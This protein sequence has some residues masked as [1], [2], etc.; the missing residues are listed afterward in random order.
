MPDQPDYRKISVSLIATVFNERNNIMELLESYRHQSVLAQEFIIIDALSNDGTNEIIELYS[1]QNSQLN[2]RLWRQQSNRSQARNFAVTKATGDYLAFTDAG[3]VLDQFWLEE[4]LRELI[5]SKQ[6]VVGGFFTGV[7]GSKLQEAITPYFLQ[8][9]KTVNVK[10]FTPTTRSLLM[11]KKLWQEMGGLDEK[12]ELSEDYQL[13]LKIRRANIPLAFAKKAI[14]YW[15]PPTTWLAFAR[16]IASFATSDIEVGIIRPK[17]LGIFVR[18]SFFAILF[19]A[20]LFFVLPVIYFSL[21]F[22]LYIFWSIYKNIHNCPR[23]WYY[24]PFLQISSDWIVMGASL[25]ALP[26]FSSR[27]S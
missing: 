5:S 17:V 11:D 18:Y 27:V 4:L 6:R 19:F 24:L 15:L 25:L 2:I 7:S 3:C 14:V 20:T 10:N 23:S 22:L 26:K 16:K 9:N 13:M 12:L 21:V 8:L 1:K